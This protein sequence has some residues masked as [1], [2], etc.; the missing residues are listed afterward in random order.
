MIVAA[1]RTGDDPDGQGG[2]SVRPVPHSE[3]E[4]NARGLNIERYLTGSAADVVDVATALEQLRMMR[5]ALREA[6]ERLDE[7]LAEAGYE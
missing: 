4:V 6:E 7:R 1:Y 3:I 2:V 5:A